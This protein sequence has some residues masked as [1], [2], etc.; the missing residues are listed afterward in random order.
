[1]EKEAMKD[2]SKHDPPIKYPM[3]LPFPSMPRHP[4]APT[5]FPML[6]LPSAAFADIHA[7]HIWEDEEW[8]ERVAGFLL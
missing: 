1:M 4:H 6:L 7:E 5:V 8:C 3:L 2:I